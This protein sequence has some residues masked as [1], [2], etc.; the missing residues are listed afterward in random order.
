[1]SGPPKPFRMLP[2]QPGERCG[3]C[4]YFDGPSDAESAVCLRH[5]HPPQHHEGP[6][7]DWEPDHTPAE[8]WCRSFEAREDAPTAK[9]KQA[10]RKA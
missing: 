8:E 3:V 1:M 10:G 4:R 9:A 5:P 7:E 2:R 6:A